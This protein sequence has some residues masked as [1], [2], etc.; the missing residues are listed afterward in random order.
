M[1]RFHSKALNRE[2]TDFDT[3]DDDGNVL[4]NVENILLSETLVSAHFCKKKLTRVRSAA[5]WL[6]AQEAEGFLKKKL[7]IIRKSEMNQKT[8]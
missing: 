2:I 5:K 8:D 3:L 1:K 6:F 7:A 4:A